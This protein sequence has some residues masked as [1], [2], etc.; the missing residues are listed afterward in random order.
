MTN[1]PS[2][3]VYMLNALWYQ[4]D[5]GEAKYR[6]YMAAVAPFVVKYGGRKLDGYKPVQSMIGDFDADLV[7]F[8]EWPD[9]DAFM[10][11][12]SDPEFLEKAQPLREAAI[13]KSLL[14]RCAPAS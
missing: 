2:E 9:W 1:S 3:K 4:P 14:I 6:E 5:G 10:N 11:F 12:V 7:F 13:S 8:V